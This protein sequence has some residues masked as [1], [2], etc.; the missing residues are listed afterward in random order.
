MNMFE[1]IEVVCVF[2][3]CSVLISLRFCCWNMWCMMFSV[4]GLVMCRLFIVCFLMLVVV[5]FLFSCG[6]VLC[7]MIGVRLIC[8]RKVSDEVRLLSLLCSIVLFIFII[9]K[10]LVLSWEKCLRYCWIFFVLFIVESR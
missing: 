6:L 8:C 10:W 4:F 1:G 2:I 5:S 3:D 9:V 7:S